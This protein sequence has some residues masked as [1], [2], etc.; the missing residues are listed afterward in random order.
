MGVSVGTEKGEMNVLRFAFLLLVVLI[1][2]A[3]GQTLNLEQAISSGSG[4]WMKNN[5]Q[6]AYSAGNNALAYPNQ[7]RNEV[8]A[9]LDIEGGATAISKPVGYDVRT[10]SFIGSA[11]V[12]TLGAGGLLTL[13]EP[14]A[15]LTLVR[16]MTALDPSSYDEDVDNEI[17]V[18][19]A[20]PD[21]SRLA[22]ASD[23]ALQVHNAS[24]LAVITRNM[25]SEFGGTFKDLAY[26]PD[27]Q[28][29][30]VATDE[31]LLLY[32][33]GEGFSNPRNSSATSGGSFEH[34]AY[35]SSFVALGKSD[36]LIDFHNASDLNDFVGGVDPLPQRDEQVKALDFS[37]DNTYLAVAFENNV[38]LHMVPNTT[39]GWSSASNTG[40][41]ASGTTSVRLG[42]QG[43][44]L[45]WGSTTNDTK[46]F[47]VTRQDNMGSETPADN[48][49]SDSDFASRP[50]SIIGYAV[51]L[52]A[53]IG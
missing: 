32:S 5:T 46:R 14:N 51:A 7:D 29:L 19:S 4:N 20:S 12:A 31:V 11:R 26:S 48:Q 13:H 24:D 44:F 9:I 52:L 1:P 50:L 45:F 49:E 15:S 35:G 3:E 2:Q 25:S 47:N 27:S 17:K 21:G 22:F 41:P 36:G 42:S 23:D 34:V 16:N 18:S 43:D 28:L 10:V 37:S 33:E 30:L 39:D 6:L 8:T 53:L 40:I 38:T